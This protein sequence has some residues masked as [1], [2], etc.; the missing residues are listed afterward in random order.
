MA[1]IEGAEAARATATGMAAVTTAVMAQVR[2]GDHAVASRALFGGCRY[3]IEDYLPRWGVD[4]TLV[5]G[6]DLKAFEQ[7]MRPNTKLVFLE[8]PTNPA[9]DLVDIAGVAEIA[10]AHGAKLV[11]DNVFGHRHLAKS[12]WHSAPTSSSIRPPSISTARAGRWAAS[13]SVPRN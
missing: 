5:D 9:L 8:T 7:A 12:R 6:R 10:H 3:V 2:A 13:F 4:S 11:V 1:L